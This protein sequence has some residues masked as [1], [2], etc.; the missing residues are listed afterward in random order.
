M[1]SWK[2]L[3]C[4]GVLLG[5]T[6]GESSAGWSVHILSKLAAGRTGGQGAG[7]RQPGIRDQGWGGGEQASNTPR[8]TG[9][10]WRIAKVVASN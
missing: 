3:D 2:M 10:A 4:T 7:R 5:V 6:H 9:R 8:D 1:K